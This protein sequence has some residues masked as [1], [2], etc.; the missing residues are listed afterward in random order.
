[1]LPEPLPHALALTPLGLLMLKETLVGLLFGFTIILALAAF[2]VAGELIGFQM[3]FSAAS[4]FSVFTMEQTTVIGQFFYL[5]AMLVFVALDGHHA[6]IGAL[7]LSFRV[8]P[9]QSW[10]AEWGSLK[11]WVSLCGQVLETGVKLALP[12]MAALFI[13]NAALGLIA[14]TM[15]QINVFVIGLP[16]QIAAGFLVLVLM[17]GS[18]L[19]AETA[20]FRHWAHDIKGLIGVLAP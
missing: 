12:L 13:T 20:V 5:L 9:L 4:V 7:D 10:P 8:L 3:M 1:V 2:Q 16:L 17:L 18:L 15:P 6:L 11:V 14:R 19:Q